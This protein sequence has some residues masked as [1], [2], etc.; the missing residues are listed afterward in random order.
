MRLNPVVRDALD[1]IVR[2]LNAGTGQAECCT[3]AEGLFVPLDRFEQ[4]GVPPAVA[5]RALGEVRLLVAERNGSQGPS[6]RTREFNGTPTVG[7]V[8]DPRSIDGV[9]L[10][11]FLLPQ[12]QGT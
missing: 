7:L 8:I 11:G 3:I 2:T 6:T 9:D 1:G 12:P 10:Q 4:R 5:L